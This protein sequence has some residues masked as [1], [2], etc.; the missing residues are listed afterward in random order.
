MLS[1]LADIIKRA[2]VE[3]SALLRTTSGMK[4]G[5]RSSSS[6]TGPPGAMTC[7]RSMATGRRGDGTAPLRCGVDVPGYGDFDDVPDDEMKKYIGRLTWDIYGGEATACRGYVKR[8]LAYEKR[9]GRNLADV[10]GND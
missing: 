10:D 5:A 7:C 1:D 3:V 8:M 9:T 4:G 2:P 6:A